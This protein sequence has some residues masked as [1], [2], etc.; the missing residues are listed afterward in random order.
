MNELMLPN[1]LMTVQEVAA[2]LHVNVKTVR[3]RIDTGLLQV[4]R[5]GRVIRIHPNEVKRLVSEGVSL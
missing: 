5:M 1:R 3:R 4:I 2:A